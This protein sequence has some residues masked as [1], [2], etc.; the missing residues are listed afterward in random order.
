MAISFSG[1]ATGLDTGSIVEQ[2]MAAERAPIT[3]LQSDRTWLLSRQQAYKTFDS[4]LNSFLSGIQKLG[5]SDDLQQKTA[6]VSR[7]DFLSASVGVDAL[8]GTSYQIE[9]V[10]LAQVQK[11]VSQGYQ[12]K[13]AASFGMGSLTLNVGDDVTTIAID[14]T[15]NSLQGIMEAINAADSGVT[16][17]IINDG[18]DS[19]Y[20][21]V[22]TGADVA[23]SFS[24][25]SDLPQFNGDVTTLTTGGYADAEAALFGGG[26]LSLST[27]FDIAITANSSLNAIRDAINAESALTGVSATVEDDGSGGYKLSLAGG[28]IVS[29]D[30][31]GGDGADPF[32]MATTQDATQAHIR[33][34]NIDIYSTSN[35]LSEAV[36]GVTLDLLSAEEGTTTNLTVDLNEDAIKAQI[37]S[38]VTGYN[39]VVSFVTSQSSIN[40]SDGG[41]LSGDSGL[42]MVKRRLQ[43]MLTQQ[44]S[45]SGTFTALSQL[46]LQ[47]QRNGTLELDDDILTDAIQNDLSSVEKLLVGENGSDG[48]AVVFQNYLED[49]TDSSDGLLASNQERTETS[50][51]R[52]DTRIGQIE[53]RLDHK[54]ETMLAQFNAMELLVSGMNS[55]SSFLTSQLT[56][57]ENLWN[58]KK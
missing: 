41:I 56:A 8:P 37:K 15:N 21:L 43:N 27:G 54:E 28:D 42:S 24:L 40:G 4:K 18:T 26:T 20:R 31:S 32:S 45:N 11:G 13:E 7:D 58:Y 9:V 14:E 25:E 55:Q 50:I 53:S 22:L 5:S 2:L 35:T 6:S 16:A 46:G 36:P 39:D 51:R 1:L 10:S 19:P 33:V 12:D 29:T 44:M 57:L 49:I 34:D 17:S 23:T 52:I 47:T 3:S 48:I 38:F 30:L